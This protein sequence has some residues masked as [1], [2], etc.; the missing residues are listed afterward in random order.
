MT[1]KRRAVLDGGLAL[2]TLLG[3]CFAALLV[4]AGRVALVAVSFV[5][6]VVIAGR[7]IAHLHADDLVFAARRPS[8]EISARSAVRAGLVAGTIGS[9]SLGRSALPRD[10]SR[11]ERRARPRRAF[12]RSLDAATR[13]KP[14]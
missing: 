11:L 1:E 13:P 3:G 14:G 5:A 6:F 12:P 4:P 9:L 2:A 8:S 7:A 10:A